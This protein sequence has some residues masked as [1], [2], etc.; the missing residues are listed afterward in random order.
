VGEGRQALLSTL[1]WW[2][3]RCGC[4]TLRRH[5][6]TQ[7]ALSISPGVAR[8]PPEPPEPRSPSTASSNSSPRA[9]IAVVNFPNPALSYTSLG[10]MVGQGYK[11]DKG[12][13]SRRRGTHARSAALFTSSL[14]G[15]SEGL[16]LT[17]HTYKV[18][19]HGCECV[20]VCGVCMIMHKRECL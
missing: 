14:K 18:Q 5:S 2:A 20:C 8:C 4:T 7:N 9:A 16:H 19:V 3:A 6:R 15:L 10:R 17:V 13:W 1:H 11:V 12:R